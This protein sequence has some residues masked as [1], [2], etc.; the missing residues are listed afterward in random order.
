MPAWRDDGFAAL[1]VDQ[2]V[3]AVGIIGTIGEHLLAAQAADEIAGECHILLLARPEDEAD[4]QANRID[5][6][7]VLVP[8]P[9]RD[10][11]SAWA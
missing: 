10:R 3:G 1:F 9:P 7:M 5:Y 4:R 6:G 8:N 2:I 11:P